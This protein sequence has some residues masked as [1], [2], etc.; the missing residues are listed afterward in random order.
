MIYQV[1][2]PLQPQSG[3]SYLSDQLRSVSESL[4]DAEQPYGK[5]GGKLAAMT[6][7]KDTKPYMRW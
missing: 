4:D 3:A 6:L 1:L 5:P 2:Q 7:I